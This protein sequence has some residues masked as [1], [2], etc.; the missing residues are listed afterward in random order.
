[1]LFKG[2]CFLLSETPAPQLPQKVRMDVLEQVLD[3]SHGEKFSLIFPWSMNQLLGCMQDRNPSWEPRCRDRQRSVMSLN[4]GSLPHA[5]NTTEKCFQQV[6]NTKRIED[7]TRV[8]NPSKAMSAESH[9]LFPRMLLIIKNQ[10]P[11]D[12]KNKM[13]VCSAHEPK[14]PVALVVNVHQVSFTSPWC[15]FA[16]LATTNI[17]LLI[18][19]AWNNTDTGPTDITQKFGKSEVQLKN[20]HLCTWSSSILGL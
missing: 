4:L 16:S 1:M 17:A 12:N 3:K 18:K 13:K 7:D 20:T 10:Y 6:L 9:I 8:S 2:L 19:N 14:D 5:F 11:I 15:S